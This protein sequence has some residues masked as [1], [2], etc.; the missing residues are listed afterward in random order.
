M[1][2]QTINLI[3]N[4]ASVRHYMPDPLP[5]SVIESITAA[6]Q[7][8]STSANMQAYSVVV[9]TETDKRK[10]LAE[11]C[12]N[13]QFIAEAPVFLAWCADLARID[14]ACHLRGF[15]Q[16]T[17][18]MESFL[19]AVVDTALAA[20]T[21]AL[22]AE[23]LGLGICYI[24]SIRNNPQQ[25][26]DMLELPR[27]TFPIV[28]MTVGWP[29]KPAHLRPRLSLNTILHWD[30]YDRSHEDEAL[31]EYDQAMIATGI[32]S[33]RQLPFPEKPSEMIG[34]G[35]TEHIARRVSRAVRTNLRGMIK[36]QGFGLK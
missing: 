13:Q 31:G 10:H 18:Y 9:V 8:A 19:V 17:N 36:K 20:Q 28:G 23:S 21:A 12:G 15:V 35:W 30:H 6:G 27:L 33:G 14:R 7:R 26:I 11:L 24:G 4:H 1:E 22:A 5:A 3:N 29:S 25:V 2:N 32:Y 34:Y 16:D